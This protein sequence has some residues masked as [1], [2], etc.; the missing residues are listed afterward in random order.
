[1][2][3]LVVRMK[4]NREKHLR[5]QKKKIIEIWGDTPLSKEIENICMKHNLDLFKLIQCCEKKGQD[6]R[7]AMGHVLAMPTMFDIIS[8]CECGEVMGFE[9]DVYKELKKLYSD[10]KIKC[11]RCDHD[12]FEKLKKVTIQLGYRKGGI[13][14]DLPMKPEDL[15]F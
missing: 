4:N 12:H 15:G 3:K 8:Q 9:N 7:V 14:M 1:M 2:L 10:G 6:I 5:L 13:S 11:K